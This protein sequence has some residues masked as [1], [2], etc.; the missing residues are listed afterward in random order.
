MQSELYIDKRNL[1]VHQQI[2]MMPKQMCYIH[3]IKYYLI[4]GYNELYHSSAT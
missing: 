4:I 1:T 3:E 2:L